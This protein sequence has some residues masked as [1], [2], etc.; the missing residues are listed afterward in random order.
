MKK[1]KIKHYRTLKELGIFEFITDVQ[2]GHMI[3]NQDTIFSV[4]EVS[5]IL[6]SQ[7]IEDRSILY[8]LEVTPVEK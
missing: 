4:K 2:I 3:L 6:N 1:Y 8:V 5:H 7:N